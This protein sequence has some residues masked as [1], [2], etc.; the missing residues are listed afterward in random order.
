MFQFICSVTDYI[1]SK[2]ISDTN[3]NRVGT[4]EVPR[5]FPSVAQIRETEFIIIGS[6]TCIHVMSLFISSLNVCID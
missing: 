5:V 6:D 1:F 3:W 4:M 2:T